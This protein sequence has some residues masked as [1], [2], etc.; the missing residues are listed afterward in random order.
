MEM[1]PL[2]ALASTGL[3]ILSSHATSCGLQPGPALR[4]SDEITSW[5]RHL[6]HS[7]LQ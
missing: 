3:T 7:D 1:P 5:L 4:T 2:R 6:K